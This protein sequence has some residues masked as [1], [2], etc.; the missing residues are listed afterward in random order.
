MTWLLTSDLHLTD[1]P[2]DDYRFGIFEWL[3]SAQSRHS[4][5]HTFLLGDLTDRKDNHSANLVNRV[6]A[7]L[8][9]LKPPIYILMGNHDYIAH[10]SPFFKF[11]NCIEGLHFVAEPTFLRD[12]TL[13]MI[14]HMPD[15]A[16][17]DAACDRMPQNSALMAHCTL[18]GAVSEMGA[19]LTGLQASPVSRFKPGAR[20]AGDVHKP[21]TLK[22]GL[23]YVGS[24]Y[25]VR[26]GDNFTPRCLLVRGEK[27]EDLHFPCL[28]KWSLTIRDA[29]ELFAHPDLKK[30]D[31]IKITIQLTREE[32]V[33]WDAHKQ[34]VLA[35]CKELGLE[36]FG[37]GMDVATNT[38]DRI[39]ADVVATT[40]TDIFDS[41]CKSEGVAA[42]IKQA[43]R[44][45]LVG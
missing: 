45:L 42:N 1:R 12:L 11:L 2:K 43:G 3:A 30:G 25:H 34:R 9:V 14:P 6:V 37:V 35:A 4:V 36:V 22:C 21:Q 40:P 24:P 8:S 26:F 41:F 19:P 17:F 13:S 27:Q 7:G 16:R 44:E 39:K 32:V 10:S 15:Q 33:G 38:P 18:A 20:W 5:G 29:D 23:T 28:S 31:Q